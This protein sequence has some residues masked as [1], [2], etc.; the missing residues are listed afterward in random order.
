M[1]ISF[2]NIEKITEREMIW[3]FNNSAAS[4]GIKS[5]WCAMVSASCFGSGDYHDSMT[6]GMLNS[7]SRFR[8][9]DKVYKSISLDSQYILYAT[10]SSMFI[11]DFVLKVFRSLAPT[12]LSQC[13][14]EKEAK[15]LE[16]TCKRILK[17][18]SSGEDSMLI[19]SIRVLSTKKFTA[20]I[21]EFGENYY[22]QTKKSKKKSKKLSN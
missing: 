5:N 1:K 21:I 22:A 8:I 16:Q 10:Y 4:L 17:H 6:N 13:K 3:F 12:A 15:I 18:K 19:S 20:A 7:I 2:E 14:T 11:N 9:I